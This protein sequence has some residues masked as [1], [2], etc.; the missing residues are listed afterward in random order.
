MATCHPQQLDLLPSVLTVVGAEVA[1]MSVS[2]SLLL[3]PLSPPCHKAMTWQV[4]TTTHTH[5][6]TERERERER[7]TGTRTCISCNR[8]WP[9][10]QHMLWAYMYPLLCQLLSTRGREGY[11]QSSGGE[12]TATDP[13]AVNMNTDTVAATTA[14]TACFH[15]GLT[16]AARAVMGVHS[17]F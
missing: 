13:S 6:H 11:P 9:N 1:P 8:R 2:V 15:G 12:A 16:R 5:T 17:V 7:D 3:L 10:T 14:T 4:I